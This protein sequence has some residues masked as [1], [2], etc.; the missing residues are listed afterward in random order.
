MEICITFG[1]MRHCFQLPVLTVPWRPGPD[2]GPIN[3]KAF[4]ADATG[5]RSRTAEAFSP[6]RTRARQLRLIHLQLRIRRVRQGS[7]NPLRPGQQVPHNV[8]GL[9]RQ[10]FGHVAVQG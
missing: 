9:Y 7:R 10:A 1:G 8:I 6:L 2:P 3:H 4:L 5:L